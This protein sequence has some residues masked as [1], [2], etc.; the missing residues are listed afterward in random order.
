MNLAVSTEPLR[1]ICVSMYASEQSGVFHNV[2]RAHLAKALRTRDFA[3]ACVMARHLAPV[4]SHVAGRTENPALFAATI[5]VAAKF[6]D[7]TIATTLLHPFGLTAFAGKAALR[8]ANLLPA[9]GI[10]WCRTA[11][12]D[13]ESQEENN[14]PSGRL[15]W[16]ETT[17]PIPC[18]TLCA[19]PGGR[20]LAGW[21]LTKQWEFIVDRSR[22]ISKY[23]FAKDITRELVSL[24]NP[25][26]CAIESSRATRQPDLS[27]RIVA[28]LTSDT[29]EAPV[30]VPM[31]VLRRAQQDHARTTRKTWNFRS[32][33]EH[34]S[35][36]ITARLNQPTRANNNWSIETPLRCSCRLC[37]KLMEYLSAPHKVRFEWPLAK[38][39]RAHIH[40]AID[41][42]DLPV[43]HVTR[44]AGRPFTLVLEKTSALFKRDTAERQSL[45][46]DLE[47]LE[48]TAVEF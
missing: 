13:W 30:Q 31:G 5:I 42:H 47:W 10:D 24:C 45:R 46:E 6:K 17:L 16:I 21:I 32:V 43:T 37:A 29:S 8:F 20:E 22:Q 19:T 34:C 38:D 27:A 1:E 25:I 4:W 14:L 40:R 23:A 28:F 7:A 18:R 9:Y 41:G 12:Q 15:K 48:K 39:Q 44:R 36:V 33:H 11:F 2:I 26:L 3:A 35:R